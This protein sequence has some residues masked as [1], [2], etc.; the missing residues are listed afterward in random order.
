MNTP[1]QLMII[2]KKV[3]EPK[4]DYLKVNLNE[5]DLDGVQRAF[6]I[7]TKYTVRDGKELCCYF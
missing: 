5:T 6:E 1:V 3:R 4:T 2:I 7:N